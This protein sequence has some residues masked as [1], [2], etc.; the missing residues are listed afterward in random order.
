[1]QQARKE[2]TLSHGLRG[3]VDSCGS[4][5]EPSALCNHLVLV[6]FRADLRHELRRTVH[7][8]YTDS[9]TIFEKESKEGMEVLSY[10]E[11]GQAFAFSMTTTDG[12]KVQASRNA[13]IEAGSSSFCGA[14]PAAQRRCPICHA[15]ALV[16]PDRLSTR[17]C[18]G[19]CVPLGTG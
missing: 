8:L 5:A 4:L 17:F 7:S 13:S 3:R 12:N 14:Q 11:V 16:C 1:M 15:K 2:G 18:P 19:L 10:P 9:Y 6:R